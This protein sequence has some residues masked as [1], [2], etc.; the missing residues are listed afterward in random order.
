MDALERSVT[1]HYDNAGLLER[2]VEALKASGADPDNLGPDDLAP[3]EEFHIGGRKATAHALAAM[4]LTGNEHVL[5][6]GCGIGGAARFIAAQTGCRVTGIDLTAAYIEAAEALTRRT[7]Q[8]GAVDFKVASALDMPFQNGEF[9]AAIT[10]HVAMNIQDRASLYGEIARVLKPGAVFCVY[11]V[12][13][14]DEAPLTFPVPWAQS[15]ETSHLTTPEETQAL[16]ESGGFEVRHV[17]DR[18]EAAAEFF[19]QAA[20]ASANGPPALGVHLVMGPNAPLYLKNVRAN[21]EN[22]LIAPVQMIAVRR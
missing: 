5:D 11:D 18:S 4:A 12:M 8:D 7:G 13:K 3:V 9:D 20:A 2:I 19:K 21:M 14:K 15:E 17:E 16:M 1:E 6:V 22:G 10:I